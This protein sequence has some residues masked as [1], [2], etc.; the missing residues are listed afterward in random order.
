MEF[1][2]LYYLFLFLI[3][4][5]R[6]ENLIKKITKRGDLDLVLLYDAG[7]MKNGENNPHLL[8]NIIEL[9]K[10]IL[11]ENEKKVS[12][13]YITYDHLNVTTKI[14]TN[15][16]NENAFEK[17]REVVLNT[18]GEYSEKKSHHLKA[19][20]YVGIKHFFNSTDNLTKMVIMFMNTDGD[21]L[22]DDADL[23]T[24]HYLFDRKKIILNVITK[25]KFKNYCNYIQKIGSNTNELLKCVFKNSYFHNFM[26]T[27]TLNKF[28][29]DISS[30]AVCTDWSEW[31]TCSNTCNVG[32]HF[33]KRKSLKNEKNAIDGLYKRRGKSCLEQ[34]NFIF[35][36]CFNTSCDHSLDK[37][38]IELDLSILLDDSSKI[39]QE[40][41]TKYTIPSIRKMISHLNISEKLVNI[42]LTTFSN[43]VYNWFDFSNILSKD[44]D[45]L[46]IFLG[47]MRYNFGDIS[48][49]INNAL[50]F[51]HDNVLNSNFTRPNAKKVLI[52]FN[53]GD[54]EEKSIS[55]VGETIDKIKKTYNAEIY[56][57]CID[58]NN[59]DNCKKL[60]ISSNENSNYKYSYSLLNYS[61]LLNDILEIQKNM[62]SNIEYNSS[63][64]KQEDE[65]K[66]SKNCDNKQ[67]DK[68]KPCLNEKNEN[69]IKM[70]DLNYNIE[71]TTDDNFTLEGESTKTYEGDYLNDDLSRKNRRKFKIKLD[72][73]SSRDLNDNNSNKNKMIL[74]SLNNLNETYVNEDVNNPIDE[75]NTK[76]D[77]PSSKCKKKKYKKLVNK[78]LLNMFRKKRKF[79]IKHFGEESKNKVKKFIQKVEYEDEKL[80]ESDKKEEEIEQE[81]DILLDDIFKNEADSNDKKITEYSSQEEENVKWENEAL[82][83]GISVSEIYKINRKLMQKAKEIQDR[84]PEYKFEIHKKDIKFP[85]GEKDGEME[86]YEKE[87]NDDYLPNA[88]NPT[89]SEKKLHRKKRSVYFE[90]EL[91]K[92]D[93]DSSYLNDEEK[94]LKDN[95]NEEKKVL[96]VNE[97]DKNMRDTIYS[98]IKKKDDYK[99]LK[100]F[101]N[102]NDASSD[103]FIEPSIKEKLNIKIPITKQEENKNNDNSS[104]EQCI[105]SFNKNRTNCRRRILPKDD[106]FYNRKYYADHNEYPKA[107]SSRNNRQNNTDE[108]ETNILK[109]N[110][111]NN[112]KKNNSIHNEELKPTRTTEPESSDTVESD[113][114]SNIEADN[115]SNIEADNISN[116]EA[117]N[118][119]NIEAD[120]ISNIEAD[121]ISNVE[122]DNLSNAKSA[123][124]SNDESKSV[125]DEKSNSLSFK[126]PRISS[127]RKEN[128]SIIENTSHLNKEDTEQKYDMN[129][130]NQYNEEG[131]ENKNKYDHNSSPHTYKYAAACALIAF[132]SVG[133]F[134]FYLYYRKNKRIVRALDSNEF[135]ISSDTKESK[136]KEQNV[137]LNEEYSWK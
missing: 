24:V 52:I 3:F 38:D 54:I 84:I 67:K 137:N 112:T 20:N 41:W 36:E 129:N 80:G 108:F 83:P 8:K 34:R 62:C 123:N 25:A 69:N 22:S 105:G 46:L 91:N 118:I 76:N 111:Q 88:E 10:N 82:P 17:F 119:S 44:R 27:H 66:T 104:D 90:N 78:L 86:K 113:N 100:K 79:N 15:N 2:K 87:K 51:V 134:A 106:N 16:K 14:T 6:S 92:Y 117:D 32:S 75:C 47:Y 26:L 136:S 72:L 48:K 60:S 13:S 33:I 121:N 30:N 40:T 101:K 73:N 65:E 57:I 124:I 43:T 114:I 109:E 107:I 74:R 95:S 85:E 11:V 63:H 12:I 98:E 50:K 23:N 64:E 77:V 122:S 102:T 96:L 70:L 126:E 68:E 42:S 120:N 9:G 71:G 128:S 99:N 37:C 39:S 59:E 21:I 53:S 55:E 110:Y 1:I 125:E 35:Q 18:K 94:V 29:D 81:F 115:I 97:E 127:S 116:I 19:L 4:F 103:V 130:I 28:Y 58:N 135:S 89:N 5:V 45:E 131:E 31:S 61:D 132:V 56:S 133:I 49:N 93:N 7:I